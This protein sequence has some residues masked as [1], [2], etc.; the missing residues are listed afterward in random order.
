MKGFLSTIDKNRVINGILF[1]SFI[2]LLFN[3]MRTYFFI[4][5]KGDILQKAN[6]KLQKAKEENENLKRQL[7]R[8][9]SPVFIEKEA[10]NKLNMGK[11]GEILLLMPT[12]IPVE[13]PTPTPVDTSTNLE[14]WKKVFF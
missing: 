5:Q 11:E 6:L 8:T 12:I 7:A 4:Q 10:R 14:K 3:V 1:L 9:Q 2:V 13:D